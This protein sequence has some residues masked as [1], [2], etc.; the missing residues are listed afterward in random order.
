MIKAAIFDMDGVLI[1][2]EPYWQESRHQSIRE[3]GC[4]DNA[5]NDGRNHR[6]ARG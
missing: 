3:S 1:D 2:S 5:R 4:A 6:P